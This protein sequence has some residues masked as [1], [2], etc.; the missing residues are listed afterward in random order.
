[1]KF[2]FA[3]NALTKYPLAE[4]LEKIRATGFESAE[5]LADTP[6]ALMTKVEAEET[7]RIKEK[8]AVLGLAVSNINANTASGLNRESG[9]PDPDDFEPALCN[10]SPEVRK[11]RIDYT[12]RAID[13]AAALG[14][15]SISITSGRITAGASRP[16]ALANFAA[17]LIPVLKKAEDRNIKVGIEFEPGLLIG[18]TAELLDF[19]DTFKHPLLGANFDIGHSAVVG[20]DVDNSIRLLGKKIFHIHCE[21][22]NN[23]HH[24]HLIPG[25]GS[26]DLLNI[27]NVLRDIGYSGWLTWELYTYRDRPD[28]AL[29]KTYIFSKKIENS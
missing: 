2:G 5:I 28:E 7:A 1:M 10:S 23:G 20:E 14:A 3:T 29:K 16:E 12:R 15:G 27:F 9:L 13:F 17:A 21:D 22:I 8:L 26:L 6:H 4:A 24:F 19:L 25:E 11:Q 18:S